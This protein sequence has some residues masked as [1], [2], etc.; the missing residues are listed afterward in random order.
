MASKRCYFPSL[1]LE[2]SVPFSPRG[3]F[4][5]LPISA[6]IAP[7]PAVQELYQVPQAEI[8]LAAVHRAG[9]KKE[10]RRKKE[11]RRSPLICFPGLCLGC[12]Q[13][14]SGGRRGKGL[15]LFGWG[16]IENQG[17]VRAGALQIP[18]TSRVEGLAGLGAF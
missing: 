14:G 9:R 17:S 7:R 6:R 5:A 1:T 11:L 2:A 16:C 12:F 15:A 18:L 4:Q 8:F 13:R 3:C 10:T